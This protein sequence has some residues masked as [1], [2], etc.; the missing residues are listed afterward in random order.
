MPIMGWNATW[1]TGDAIVDSQHKQLF[2]QLERLNS[3]VTAGKGDGE[4]ERTLML[5][6]EY[7]ETHFRDEESLMRKS[8]YGG[9]ARHMETHVAMGNQV[10]SLIQAY[11][12]DHPPTP[13]AVLVFLGAWLKEHLNGEDRK[14]AEH[15]RG[16]SEWPSPST[17]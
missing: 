13:E 14:L 8:G 4:T 1:E 17:I 10:D 16:N 5:M 15:L 9:L 2:Q 3:A 11:L 12:K 6:G 7:V